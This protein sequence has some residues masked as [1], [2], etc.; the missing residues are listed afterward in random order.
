MVG[1]PP[2]ERHYPE[3]TFQLRYY[4]G[5]KMVYKSVGPDSKIA[6]DQKTVLENLL[7]T[8]IT[9]AAAGVQVVEDPE[10]R[11][12]AKAQAA[13][14]QA[15]EDRGSNEAAIVYR[16]ALKEF[17]QVVTKTYVDELR[18]EDILAYQ[19]HLRKRGCS[20]RTIHNRWANAK[21][22]FLYCGFDS[23]KMPREDGDTQA[24]TAPKYEELTPEVYEPEELKPFFAELED[25]PSAYTALQ[26]MLKCG[27]REQEMQFLEWKNVN[28]KRGIIHIERN[29]YYGFKVK[30]SEQRDIPIPEKL[31]AWLQTYRAAHPNARLVSST[32]NGKP[33]T[34]LL[35]IVKRAATRAGLNCNAC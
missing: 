2:V 12:I 32:A 1:D 34:K 3:G 29:P 16:I 7:K 30:D 6:T 4:E 31:V 5:N 33:Q 21:A 28:L 19:R 27:L 11:T 25:D 10:R 9:A 8:R 20:D 18:A 13:F 15:T 14:I 17:F 23:K 35:R 22:F 26:I 24:L